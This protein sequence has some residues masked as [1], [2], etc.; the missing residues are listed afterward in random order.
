MGGEGSVSGMIH[1]L[2][3]NAKIQ[4]KSNFYKHRKKYIRVSSNLK[5]D[6]K[7]ATKEELL[8]IKNEVRRKNKR[9][10]IFDVVLYILLIGLFV[11]WL[12]LWF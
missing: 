7:K 8:A 3:N 5:I 10:Y 9:K 12:V 6:F 11:W 1:A 2:K 4:N